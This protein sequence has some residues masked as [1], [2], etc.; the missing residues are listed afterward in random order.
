MDLAYR[1]T[2]ITAADD[3]A[4]YA[5][6]EEVLLTQHECIIMSDINLPHIDWSLQRPTPQHLEANYC[7]LL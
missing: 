6:L 3:D 5:A 1:N 2:T 4:F 7:Y